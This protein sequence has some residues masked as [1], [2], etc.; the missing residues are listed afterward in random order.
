MQAIFQNP[1]LWEAMPKADSLITRLREAKGL[2]VRELARQL[3]VNHS[4]VLFWER[5]GKPPRPDLLLPMAEA[6][7]VT[8]DELLGKPKPARVLS[9]GGKARQAFEAVS[10]LP[11]R[12]QEKILDVVNALVAQAGTA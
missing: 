6:L 8:V 9:P 12:Q 11:R 3:G 10:K 2:S 5:E 4:N 7:G 1:V